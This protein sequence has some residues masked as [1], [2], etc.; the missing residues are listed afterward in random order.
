MEFTGIRRDPAFSPGNRANDAAIFQRCID[1][2]RAL[3]HSVHV[4]E[5][6]Q[7]AEW[8][9]EDRNV[10]HMTRGRAA[11][12]ALAEMEARGL[13]VIN[14]VAALENCS[15]KTAHQMMIRHG[16]PCPAAVHLGTERHAEATL[17]FPAVWLKRTDTCT[18]GPEDVVFVDGLRAYRSALRR[19][20]ER[21]IAEVQVGDHHHGFHVKFYGVGHSRFFHS[22]RP[23]HCGKPRTETSPPDPRDPGGDYDEASLATLA[24]AAARALK[25]VVWGGDAIIAPDGTITVIDLNDFPSFRPCRET[26]AK[27]I[28][29]CFVHSIFNGETQ[30]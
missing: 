24:F 16:I 22:F 14:S 19:F 11:L 18:Q 20:A 9:L 13:R 6:S 12:D 26:A 4:Y 17:P 1:E 27:A 25:V 7:I 30:P 15:R 10:L 29:E 28:A 5:E 23:D 8:S 21:G 3:G 2:L